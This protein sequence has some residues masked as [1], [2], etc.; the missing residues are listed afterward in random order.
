MFYSI[1]QAAAEGRQEG[2]VE[3]IR[4]RWPFLELEILGHLIDRPLE[5]GRIDGAEA[6]A[7]YF[8]GEDVVADHAAQPFQLEIARSAVHPADNLVH[9]APGFL[10][11][12]MRTG[13][14]RAQEALHRLGPGGSE[15][16]IDDQREPVGLAAIIGVWKYCKVIS[17]HAAVP[18]IDPC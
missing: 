2:V 16:R 1:A 3:N 15:P 8:D 13:N 6:V 9:R 18:Q 4:R 10:D 7:F 12:P 11:R 5:A 14:H 17:R